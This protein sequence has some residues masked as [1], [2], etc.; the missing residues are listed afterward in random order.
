MKSYVCVI[1]N[2]LLWDAGV[3][4]ELRS[5]AYHSGGGVQVVMNQ[6]ETWWWRY[7]STAA[8]I[9]VTCL[10]LGT[11]GADP[12]DDG[13]A[14]CGGHVNGSRGQISTPNFPHEFPVPIQCRWVLYAPPGHKIVLYF[15]QY[16]LRESFMVAEYT[17]YQ[18]EQFNTGRNNL[19]EVG[20][21]QYSLISYK[22]Y[23]V[24][25]FMVRQLGNI[26]LRVDEFLLDVYGFNITYEIV[27][28]DKVE[29]LDVCTV[30][31]CS[32]LGNCLA[33]ADY[34]DY[35]CHCFRGY[36]GDGCQF[37]R[38]CNPEKGINFCRNDGK[39]RYVEAPSRHKT[40]NE[41]W[42]DDGPTA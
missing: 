15:T 41:C 27:D 30:Y 4:G 13:M 2:E 22:P 31:R 36:Y 37:G 35:S 29:R 34:E 32:F 14:R 24:I 11:A 9:L 39:C 1:Q 25:D 5:K 42:F 3:S 10:V 16:Y 33:T 38:Y 6:M 19:G 17:Y 40:L 12:H 8:W 21:D 7:L 26:H 23:L 20:F 18:D 28:N